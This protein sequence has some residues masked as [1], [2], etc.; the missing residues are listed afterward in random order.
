MSTESDIAD[1]KKRME[2]FEQT[3]AAMAAV[4]G[5]KA[6]GAARNEIADDRDLDSQWGNPEIRKDPPKWIE[7][8]KASYVGRK[9]SACPSDYLQALAGFYDW[10]ADRDEKSGR[11]DAKGRPTAPYSRRDAAR[12]RG[13]A[14]RNEENQPPLFDEENPF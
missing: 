13:W 2:R 10:Q 11:V 5:G 12:A 4:W 3:F 14:K 1:L 9:L 6:S 8:G 7:A